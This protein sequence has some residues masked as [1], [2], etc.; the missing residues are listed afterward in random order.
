[1]SQLRDEGAFA[2]E[3]EEETTDPVV[4]EPPKKRK[5]V[6]KLF[7]LFL[8]LP[9]LYNAGYDVARAGIGDAFAVEVEQ[10][11]LVEAKKA[12]VENA[13]VRVRGCFRSDDTWWCDVQAGYSAERSSRFAV[14]IPDEKK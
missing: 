14:P 5:W 3:E 2:F 8:F 12:G 10:N 9:L 7:L 1:M 13:Y 11:M 6:A 4:Q